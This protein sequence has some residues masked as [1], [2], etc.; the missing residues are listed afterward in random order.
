MIGLA[1][2]ARIIFDTILPLAVVV[3]LLYFPVGLVASG[4]A[5]IVRLVEADLFISHAA[6]GS[7]MGPGN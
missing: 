4:F 2:L 6:M 1:P 5:P 3:W 7:I